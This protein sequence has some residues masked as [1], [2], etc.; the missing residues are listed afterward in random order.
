MA[1]T[2]ETTHPRGA[3]GVAVVAGAASGVAD[4][5]GAK[6]TQVGQGKQGAQLPRPKTPPVVSYSPAEPPLPRAS[7]VVWIVGTALVALLAWAWSFKLDEVSTGTGKVVPSSKEQMIQSLEGGILVDLK[8]REGDIVD[9]GQV[10]AQLDRTK[11]ESTVQESA[12]RVR[13]ALAMSA[14]LAAEVGGTSLAFPPE[15]QSDADLVRTETALYRSRREQLA[16][17]LAGV[18]QALVLMRRELALTEPLVSRGAASDVEVLRLKRQI[19]EAE[20]KAADIKSQYSVKAREE[21]AKANAEI[22]AQRSVTRG[23]SDS[24]TRLTFASPV[25]GIVKDIAVTTVGGVL[26]PGG[27]L[28]EIVP[29][30]EKLLVEARISPR[31]VAFIHPGQDATVKVTAY[32]YAIFGGLPGKVTTI[33]PDTIQ[34]DVKR[35]VY[36]YRVY[37][38]TDADHL[39]NSSGQSFPI[40]PGMIATVDIHTGSKSVLDYLVK[41]LNKAREALR[42]R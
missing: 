12:S 15:V 20:T 6:G 21:L 2:P 16:S 9:A 7:L 41:P 23:R 39:N 17:S 8:V 10:L 30:D 33:S 26:P 42:E 38:R 29:L 32:D 19:N 11:T 34:D 28:M 27:K 31:D 18:T 1:T 35:D 25:R 22:E 24:L 40:V 14:R 13:A 36:Y 3:G 37:I 4:P 5:Q